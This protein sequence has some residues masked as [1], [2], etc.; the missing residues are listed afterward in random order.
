MTAGTLAVAPS[1]NLAG[2]FRQYYSSAFM[3]VNLD[4]LVEM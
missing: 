2:S 4:K 3:E 1:D